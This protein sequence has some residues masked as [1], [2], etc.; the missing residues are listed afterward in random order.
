EKILGENAGKFKH[1]EVYFISDLQRTTWLPGLAKGTAAPA[2]EGGPLRGDGRKEEKEGPSQPPSSHALH[3]LQSRALKGFGD[4]GRDKVDNL[5]V[6]D[7]RVEAPFITTRT[8]VPIVAAIQN[9]GVR[10]RRNVRVE[11]LIS[12]AGTTPAGQPFSRRSPHPALVN[13]EDV[14][15]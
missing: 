11:L 12:K 8:R 3:R 6:T 15:P 13:L 2:E 5:A 9:F 14:S 7:L 10:D 4:V 1:T